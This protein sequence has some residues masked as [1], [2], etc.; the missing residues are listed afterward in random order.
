MERINTATKH[1]D[2]FGAGKHG[3][4]DGDP[5]VPVQATHL[6]AAVMNALQEEAANVVEGAGVALNGADRTQLR[7]ALFHVPAGVVGCD[8]KNN[9]GTPTSQFDLSARLVTVRNPTTAH[10]LTFRNPATKTVN[11]STAGPAANGRDQAG[12]FANGNWIH[13]YW[14][15]TPDGTLNGIASLSAENV[16]PTLPAGYTHWAYAGAVY[17]TGSA[18]VATR[19]RGSQATLDTPISVLSVGSATSQTSVSTAAAVPP[20]ALS[21]L[22]A[23]EAIIETNG[24]GRGGERLVIRPFAGSAELMGLRADSEVSANGTNST[25]AKIPNISQTFYYLWQN[26]HGPTTISARTANILVTGYTVP[27]G[28]EA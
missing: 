19:I 21:V 10:A 27:N 15:A 28:G 25:M 3:Y 23:V 14:I 20:N 4:R 24:V 6:S 17:L 9:A 26:A 11:C 12:A 13:F 18:L 5:L 2:L 22:L 7:T 16:G 8:C 1:T